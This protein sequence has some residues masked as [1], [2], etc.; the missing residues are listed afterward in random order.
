MQREGMNGLEEAQTARYWDLHTLL[1]FL[2]QSNMF[3]TTVGCGGSEAG[4]GLLRELMM[5]LRR[6]GCGCL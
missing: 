1:V 4:F 2:F 5:H 3:Y 6:G